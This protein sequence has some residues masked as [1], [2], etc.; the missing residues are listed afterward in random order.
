MKIGLTSDKWIDKE[1][2]HLL[3]RGESVRRA[4]EKHNNA[5]KLEKFRTLRKNS[6]AL[7]NRK[8]KAYLTSLGDN[9]KAN[10]K[11]FWS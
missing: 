11:R 7:I 10:P 1:V 6:K 4:A 2:R 9:L 5:F 3:K 8:L